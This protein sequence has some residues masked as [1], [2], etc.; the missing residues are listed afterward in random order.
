MVG[1]GFATFIEIH[2][3]NPTLDWVWFRFNMIFNP[4]H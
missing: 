2:H 1:Q 4:N 3:P